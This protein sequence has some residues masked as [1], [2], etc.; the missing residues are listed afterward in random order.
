MALDL[1]HAGMDVRGEGEPARGAA[2]AAWDTCMGRYLAIYV[3]L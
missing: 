3:Y 2:A 1:L